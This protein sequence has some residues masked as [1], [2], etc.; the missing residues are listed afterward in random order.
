MRVIHYRDEDDMIASQVRASPFTVS[1]GHK[2]L[3]PVH[4]FTIGGKWGHGSLPT[5]TRVARRQGC[6]VP[7]SSADR[8]LRLAARPIVDC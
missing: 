3:G 2:H 5:T 7:R 8:E 4:S 6:L 1:G